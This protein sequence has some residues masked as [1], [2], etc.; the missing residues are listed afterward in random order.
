MSGAWSTSE[1]AIYSLGQRTTNTTAYGPVW[2]LQSGAT[3]RVSVLSI[4]L[5]S[6]SSGG[7]MGLALG[8]A[9]IRGVG[10]G[11]A[12]LAEDSA[13]PAATATGLVTWTNGQGPTIP[14]T[15]LR[16]VSLNDNGIDLVQ[17]RF[18]EGLLMPLNG[19]LA[20]YLFTP[21]SL[22]LD[23]SAVIDE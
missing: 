17:W 19:S 22:A 14:S 12:F 9:P 10:A 3:D 8:W 11:V 4:E 7:V 2:E 15:F 23:I 21:Q 5:G 20:L 6:S 18:P 13:S 1:V 16:R